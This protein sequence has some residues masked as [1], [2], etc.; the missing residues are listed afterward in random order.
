MG[1]T[2]KKY[3]VVL[4]HGT[5]ARGIIPF[6]KKENAPWCEEGSELRKSCSKTLGKNT[7]F[8]P[9]VW[10]GR[11]SPTARLNAGLALRD[12]LHKLKKDFPNS[13][14]VIV[15]HSHGGNIAMYAMRDC[16]D[17]IE[18]DGLACFSTPFIH[19]RSRD[20][21]GYEDQL[22]YAGLFGGH[23]FD[24]R[25]GVVGYGDDHAIHQR[26]PVYFFVCVVIKFVLSGKRSRTSR[27]T[28]KYTLE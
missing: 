6:L 13:K 20:Y 22:L 19:V 1:E 15:S 16:L 24:L 11:N 8:Y 18:I 9:F 12:K 3:L 25:F 26:V 14:I 27:E 21:K 5:W 2:V 10:S 4:V 17:Q 28:I 23:N 7:A